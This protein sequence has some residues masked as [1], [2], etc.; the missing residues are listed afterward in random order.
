M[1]VDP[2]RTPYDLNFGLFGFQVRI[3]PFFWLCAGLFNL[4]L[5]KSEY[6]AFWFIWI[7]LVLISI[8][9]HELGHAL[10]FRLFGTNSTIVLY[11]FG[12]LAIP[13]RGIAGRWR[14][15]MVSL[16]GPLAGFVLA[17]LVF[18]SDYFTDW[19]LGGGPYA[20]F[21]YLNLMYV[22]VIW[23]IINLLP[24]YPLDGG[25]VSREICEWRSRRGMLISLKIS[26]GVAAAI[27]LYSLFCEFERNQEQRQLLAH[28]PWWFP[29][30]NLY[31]AVLFG[32]LAYQSYILLQ[33]YNRNSY[34]YQ[35][36]DDRLPW[37]R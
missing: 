6:P 14:R 5:L 8:L 7:G 13:Y 33:H 18:A 19:S 10:A 32:I 3:H 26:I 1:L 21:L 16:A 31:I 35:P 25:Q 2:G 11:A 36:A 22:N 4:H 15:I 27:V 23:G 17:G 12:G 37:E 24:V 30:G 20:A 28:L 29:T 9:V 34:H